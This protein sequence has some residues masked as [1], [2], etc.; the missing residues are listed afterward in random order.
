VTGRLPKSDDLEGHVA[1]RADSSGASGTHGGPVAAL[2][3]LC[4]L[5]AT[6]PGVVN[7]LQ[8]VHPLPG[9][10]RAYAFTPLA[11]YVSTVMSGILAVACVVFIF[12][13]RKKPFRLPVVLLV[14][15][16]AVAQTRNS[17]GLLSYDGATSVAL[18]ALVVVALSSLGPA[19]R[20]FRVVALGVFVLATW[21]LLFASLMP[22][23]ARFLIAGS[24]VDTSK[25][26][27]GDYVLAGPMTHS[28]TLGTAIVLGLPFLSLVQR[29]KV[30]RVMWATCLVAVLLSASRTALL[31]LLGW[32][33]LRAL[34]LAV[35]E[36]RGRSFRRVAL[37]LVASV[38]VCLPLL[39]QDREA[40]STRVSVWR[41][42]LQVW[43]DA[44]QY[45]FGLG[46]Y[47]EL[48]ASA[49]GSTTTTSAHNL[50]VQWLVTG[51]VTLLML[52]VAVLVLCARSVTRRREGSVL[53]TYMF[54]LLF[55]ST[56]EF[57]L[58]LTVSS[59]LFPVTGFVIAAILCI[60]GDSDDVSQSDASPSLS[61][62]R[63]TAGARSLRPG[64]TARVRH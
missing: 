12:L 20:E 47:W 5:K 53:S 60:A 41:D 6:L 63:R 15:L 35:V 64:A 52:G 62:V 49:A 24:G 58:P 25:A 27:V 31:A 45:M 56:T 44:G 39:L 1:R 29:D 23:N 7:F 18:F 48:G 4:L 32:L 9:T 19:L 46:P 26:F 40:L 57:I 30:R 55:V 42:S 17:D 61:E 33:V 22:T 2:F 34:G 50:F 54:L 43:R 8:Q 16:A 36:F 3:T 38:I 13:G 10:E 51:G 14:G 28:N 21:S 11:G 59:Q 37:L